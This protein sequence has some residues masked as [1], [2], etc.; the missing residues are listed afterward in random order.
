M[1]EVANASK[2]P[3]QMRWEG[4]PNGEGSDSLWCDGKREVRFATLRWRMPRRGQRHGRLRDRSW[5]DTAS[6]R[7]G[8]AALNVDRPCVPVI[9]YGE[10]CAD[11]LVAAGARSGLPLEPRVSQDPPSRKKDLVFGPS[12][13]DGALAGLGTWNLQ[14][15]T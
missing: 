4:R 8:V 3:E 10:A 5:C 6:D 11:L 12:T 9:D 1:S 2:C 14:R 13:W 15:K 7:E